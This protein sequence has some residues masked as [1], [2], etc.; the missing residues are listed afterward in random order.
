MPTPKLTRDEFVAKLRVKYPTVTLLSKEFDGVQQP[1][2]FKCGV[3]DHRWTSRPVSVMQSKSAN[4]C[5]K[6]SRKAMSE[7]MTMAGADVQQRIRD[8]HGD[9]LRMLGQYLGQNRPHRFKCYTCLH[10]WKAKPANVIHAESGCPACAGIVKRRN[11]ARAAKVKIETI[12]GVEV[13]YQGYEGHALK[14]LL[15]HRKIKS[16]RDIE[17]EMGGNVPV[18]KYKLGRRT[19]NYYPDFYVPMMN[20]LV[21]VKS[22]YTWGALTGKHWRKNQ[23][24]ARECIDQGYQYTLMLMRQDGSRI[25]LPKDWYLKSRDQVLRECAF[26]NA[27]LQ[28]VGYKRRRG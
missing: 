20:R 21:E 25:W 2:R 3:C 18:I 22:T 28:P 26:R 17:L 16:I 6:C 7:R 4:G 11:L 5:K 9:K 1:H 24:K 10:T 12:G 19:H 8:V 23:A 13:R 14:W 27:D 15:N